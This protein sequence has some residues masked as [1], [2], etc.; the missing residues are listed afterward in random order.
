MRIEAGRHLKVIEAGRHLKVQESRDEGLIQAQ[1]CA[2]P[3]A[4]ACK[5]K[6]IAITYIPLVN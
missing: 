2:L 4:V 3:L 6:P 1:M 5:V